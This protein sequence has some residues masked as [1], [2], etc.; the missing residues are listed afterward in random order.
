[1]DLC[2]MFARAEA[3]CWHL[4]FEMPSW[5]HI[6][7]MVPTVGALVTDVETNMVPTVGASC[8]GCRH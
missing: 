3:P 6:P 2:K 7:D 8:D 4:R 1:M 5:L